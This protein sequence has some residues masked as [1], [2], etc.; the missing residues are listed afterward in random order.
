MGL[1][2]PIGETITWGKEYTVIGVIRNI[3]MES[4]Y[5]P[6]KQAVYYITPEAGYLNIKINPNA[7]VSQALRK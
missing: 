3:L 1:K 2:N 5:E 7:S 4:P 6:V